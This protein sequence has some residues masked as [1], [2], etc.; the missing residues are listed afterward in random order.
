[1]IVHAVMIALS[2]AIWCCASG[3]G[4]SA[5]LSKAMLRRLPDSHV[6]TASRAR[7]LPRVEAP[8]TLAEAFAALGDDPAGAVAVAA[9]TDATAHR[10][11]LAD[12]K[13]LP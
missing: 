3:S 1:M 7:A 11:A 10:T 2:V 5:D 8:A 13:V 12:M 4:L 6:A 9:V